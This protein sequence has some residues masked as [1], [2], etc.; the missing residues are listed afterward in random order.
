M[1][2]KPNIKIIFEKGISFEE[3][4]GGGNLVVIVC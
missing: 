1:S 3:K 2:V 4:P